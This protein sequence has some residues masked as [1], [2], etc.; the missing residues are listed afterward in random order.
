VICIP[1]AWSHPAVGEIDP[2]AEGW[3]GEVTEGWGWYYVDFMLLLTFGGIPWQVR[4]A[5][6]TWSH[7]LVE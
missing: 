5:G 7:H 3:F 1:W 4:T 6:H 2:Y